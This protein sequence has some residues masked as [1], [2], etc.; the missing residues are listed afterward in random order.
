MSFVT[1]NGVAMPRP[2]LKDQRS[3]EILDA[4]LT[5]VARFGLDG[6]TQERIAAEAGVK[7][8]LLRHYLGNKEQMIGALADHV[9]AQYGGMIDLLEQALT[10]DMSVTDLVELL[11]DDE[12]GSDPRL[13]LAY[14]ALVTAV[15]EFPGMRDPLLASLER[16]LMVIERALVRAVPGAP[17]AQVRAV[18]QGI[19]AAHVNLDA[20]SPMNPPAQWRADL[21]QAALILALHLER[22]Q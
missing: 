15:S 14:Q 3:A 10:P 8:P 9:V 19:A 4:Y 20:L 1:K 6:A 12:G 7:R 21:K 11:F 13:M 17:Q 18:A 16:F 5:C 2:S 22:D